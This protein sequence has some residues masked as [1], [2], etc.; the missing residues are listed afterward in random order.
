MF[1]TLVDIAARS[2]KAPWRN[3]GELLD[4]HGFGRLSGSADHL[5]A[6][7]KTGDPVS[8]TLS[9]SPNRRISTKTGDIEMTTHRSNETTLCGYQLV[10]A[11]MLQ[12]QG[13]EPTEIA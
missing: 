9:T 5:H 11:A 2:L 12:A 6:V 8:S 10:I 7:F 1:L 4:D 13:Q 3:R